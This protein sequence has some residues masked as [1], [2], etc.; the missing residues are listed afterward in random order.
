MDIVWMR[1]LKKK[2]ED[3]DNYIKYSWGK[4]P[5]PIISGFNLYE[6]HPRELWDRIGG[7]GNPT[8]LTFVFPASSF[9]P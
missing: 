4:T 9:G 3:P 7:I 6:I 8:I 1:C 2:N 5:T